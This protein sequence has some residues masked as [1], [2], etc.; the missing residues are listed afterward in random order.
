MV[1]AD[2]APGRYRIG[3]T[4]IIAADDAGALLRELRT[5]VV[6]VRGEDEIITVHK[7]VENDP[8]LELVR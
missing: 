6:G 3:G 1:D 5:T 8:E 2:L 7:L 4:R